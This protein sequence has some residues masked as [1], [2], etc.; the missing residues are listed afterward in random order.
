MHVGVYMCGEAEKDW[1]IRNP[2][3]DGLRFEDCGLGSETAPASMSELGSMTVSQRAP[4]SF[5][6][7]AANIPLPPPMSA[8]ECDVLS[9]KRSAQADASQAS[10][11]PGA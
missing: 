3:E 4:T 1:R 6:S 8:S 10:Y 2:D 5:L 9:S 11:G 7:F